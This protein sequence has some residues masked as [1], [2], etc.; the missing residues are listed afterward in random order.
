LAAPF[1]AAGG[2]EM[3]RILISSGKYLLSKIRSNLVQQNVHV[4]NFEI[5]AFGGTCGCFKLEC[6]V[7]MLV[8]SS[9]WCKKLF[10]AHVLL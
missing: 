3:E 9:Y 6:F 4:S 8:V 10:N 7:H 1:I 2:L 5:T